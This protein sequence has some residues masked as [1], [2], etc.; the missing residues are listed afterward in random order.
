MV[1]AKGATR[2]KAKA[3]GATKERARENLIKGTSE[4]ESPSTMKRERKP[5]FATNGQGAMVIANMAR[6]VDSF[7]KDHKVGIKEKQTLRY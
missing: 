3:K 2:E 6:A 7:M 1:N 5:R 4:T